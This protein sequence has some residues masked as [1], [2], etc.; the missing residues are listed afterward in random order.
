MRFHFFNKKEER[1]MKKLMMSA[2]VLATAGMAMAAGPSFVIPD[3]ILDIGAEDAVAAD[4]VVTVNV[5]A[6]GGDPVAG[7]VFYLSTDPAFE[8]LTLDVDGPGTLFSQST[9]GANVTVMGNIATGS[10]TTVS[11]TLA[12]DGELKAAIATVRVPAGAAKGDYILSTEVPEYGVVSDWA[13]TPAG[14]QGAGVISIVP[15]PVS[16]LLLLAGLPLL[17]RRR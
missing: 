2:V 7:M 14:A 15:E 16:A 9:T 17:R 3:V 6:V 12:A 4:T 1:S 11:G 13:G 5:D 10:V 8:I